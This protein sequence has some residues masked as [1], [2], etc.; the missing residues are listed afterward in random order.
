[1]KN[2]SIGLNVVLAIAVAVLYY[3]HFKSPNARTK[4]SAVNLKDVHIAYINTD[5]LFEH[6]DF[7][8]TKQ[9]ELKKLED[10]NSEYLKRQAA[11]LQNELEMAQA[12][13]ATMNASQAQAA[14]ENLQ[15]KQ[16]IFMQQKEEM[17]DAYGKKLQDMNDTL[18]NKIHRYLKNYNKE[19]QF[20]YILGYQKGSGILFAKDELDVT[21]E[22]L[23]GMNENYSKEKK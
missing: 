1:M 7:F 14:Q 15:R 10:D 13:V 18:A 20:D 12:K 16:Q 6:Y 5:T 22:V 19:K 23:K 2:L 3:F 17:Q 4:P 21:P 8:V 9:K 11:S